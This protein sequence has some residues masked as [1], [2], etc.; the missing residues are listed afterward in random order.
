MTLAWRRWRFWR[1]RHQRARPTGRAV[2]GAVPAFEILLFGGIAVL[3]AGLGLDAFLLY[4]WTSERP[5]PLPLGLGAV[6]QTMV[7]TGLNLMVA[8]LL[9][10]VLRMSPGGEAATKPHDDKQPPANL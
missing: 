8:A 6:A 10:G 9:L 3:L 5:P 2:T 1:A 4:R 7:V